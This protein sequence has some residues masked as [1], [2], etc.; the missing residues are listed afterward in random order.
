MPFAVVMS[1]PAGSSHRHDGIRVHRVRDL[2]ADHLAV[3]DGIPTTTLERAIV[4]VTCVFQPARLAHLIDVETMHTRRTSIGAIGRTL[5]QVNR[6]GRFGIGRLG[7]LLDARRPAEPTPRSRLERRVDDLLAR[8]TLPRALAEHPLPGDR[9]TQRWVDR[10]WPEAK[11]ILEIDGRT[12]HAREHAMAKDRARDRA[13]ARAGWLTIRVLDDE[14][15]SCPDA[16]LDDVITAFAVR[17]AQLRRS[18]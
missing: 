10:A 11:L 1:V 5:R 9:G 15:T 18:A 14:V 13:A 17:V 3:V 7:P 16:V 4:D 6:R 2:I 12:W 8:S